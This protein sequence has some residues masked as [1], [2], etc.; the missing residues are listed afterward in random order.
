MHPLDPTPSYRVALWVEI[1]NFPNTV[2]PSHRVSSFEPL[3]IVLVGAP[4]KQ[5]FIGPLCTALQFND[6]NNTARTA[7]H[8]L[9]K[10]IGL[11]ELKS[12]GVL[13]VLKWSLVRG[14]THIPIL[15]NFTLKL[16]CMY[17]RGELKFCKKYGLSL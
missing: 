9:D 1:C 15:S 16:R 10:H 17:L 4:Y 12:S 5:C 11:G 13:Q 8:R 3:L 6:C 7:L 14:D 2:V